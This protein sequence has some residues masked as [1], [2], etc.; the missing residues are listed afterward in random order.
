MELHHQLD[1]QETPASL[2][3]QPSSPLPCYSSNS[4]YLTLFVKI[5][6]QGKLL[7]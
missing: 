7:F 2:K 4:H 1:L 5:H 3:E 6:A